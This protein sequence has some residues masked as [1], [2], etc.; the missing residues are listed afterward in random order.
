M[1]PLRVSIIASIAA[2]IM[3]GVIF[4][5]IRRRHLR[6]RYA[7]VWIATGIVL[8]ALALWRQGLNTLAGWVGVKTYPPSVIFAA[9]L[10]FMLVLVLHFS[11]VLSRLSDQNVTLAQKLALLET[12]LQEW[13]GRQR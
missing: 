13:E 1:T 6:E 3:L 5:L 4:E 2:L 12:R 10:F 11:I 9:L 8:L 7:L